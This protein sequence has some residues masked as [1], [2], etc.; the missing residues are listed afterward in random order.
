MK[1]LKRLAVIRKSCVHARPRHTSF[2]SYVYPS[3]TLRHGQIRAGMTGLRHN[4][5]HKISVHPI[6]GHPITQSRAPVGFL[7]LRKASAGAGQIVDI[8]HSYRRFGTS[9]EKFLDLP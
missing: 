1:K 5:R 8:P 7:R 6:R 9:N 4:A 3:D 2:A